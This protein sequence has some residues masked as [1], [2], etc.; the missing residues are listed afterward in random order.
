MKQF[1]N[2]SI[3]SSPLASPVHQHPPSLTAKHWNNELQE[4]EYRHYLSE[5]YGDS[6]I[7]KET[8]SN[9][10]RLIDVLSFDGLFNGP[11]VQ[12]L[13]LLEDKALF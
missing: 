13:T 7:D 8:Y 2:S 9:Y 6:T 5:V 11:L 12:N 10:S 4:W 1:I 3:S